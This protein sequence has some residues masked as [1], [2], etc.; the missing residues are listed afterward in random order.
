MPDERRRL[1]IT[2][3]AYER[4]KQFQLT[5]SK[6]VWMFWNSEKEPSPPG[7]MK[8]SRFAST[9]RYFRNGTFVMVAGE[10]DDKNTGEP[11]YL[12][13]SVFDQMM[14]IH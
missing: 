8:D 10:T 5:P 3:H 2:S 7:K 9:T 4:A 12:L 14:Y 11:I 13:L 6:L 1:K